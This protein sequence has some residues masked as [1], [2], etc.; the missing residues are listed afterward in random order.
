VIM[1]IK[2]ALLNHSL[3][4]RRPFV[5]FQCFEILPSTNMAVDVFRIGKPDT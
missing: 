4:Y 2:V 1:G 3:V 5:T